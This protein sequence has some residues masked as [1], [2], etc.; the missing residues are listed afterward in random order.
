MDI[1]DKISGTLLSASKDAAQK[2]KD[3]SDLARLRMDIRSKE[4]YINQQYQQIG[5]VY[6]ARHKDDETPKYEQIALIR[7][8]EV[9]L[10]ELKQQLGQIKGVQKCPQCGSD[11]PQEAEYC[12]KCGTKLG[13]FEEE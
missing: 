9:L 12:S 8:A 1:L 11:M 5:K 6:Y 7:E 3:L 2:A 10:N 4:D 13:I